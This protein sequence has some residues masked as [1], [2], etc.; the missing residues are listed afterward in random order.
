MSKNTSQ[1][2]NPCKDYIYGGCGHSDCNSN[3]HQAHEFYVKYNT[4]EKRRARIQSIEKKMAIEDEKYERKV[5]KELK[6]KY[7]NT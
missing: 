5:L 7:E 3:C 1:C 4:P 6:A 2:Q